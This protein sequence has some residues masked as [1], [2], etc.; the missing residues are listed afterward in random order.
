MS[1][2]AK[3]LYDADFVEWTARTA[4][5]VRSG[6]FDEVDL[7]HVAE[8]I[9]DL[10]KRDRAGVASLLFR[11]VLHQ[12]KRKIQPERDGERWRR[13]I[14]TSQPAIL[15]KVQDSPS[16]RRFLEEELQNIYRRAVRGA[17]FETGVKQADLPELCPFTLDQFLEL[18]ELDW[19]PEDR[20]AILNALP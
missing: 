13:S 5:L 4:E 7:E 14:V 15:Q 17:M 10:G 20:D 11:L 8:E 18:F 1:T 9:E 3:T 19:P 6:R 12:V 2:T 16:L